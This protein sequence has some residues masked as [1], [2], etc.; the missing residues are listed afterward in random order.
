MVVALI[1]ESVIAMPPAA[2]CSM[3]GFW[4]DVGCHRLVLA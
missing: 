1:F 4:I 3:S 2:N